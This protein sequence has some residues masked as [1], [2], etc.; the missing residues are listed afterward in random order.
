MQPITDAL[1]SE[2]FFF[3]FN[4]DTNR[5]YN[6]AIMLFAFRSDVFIRRWNR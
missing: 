3:F 4:R 5:D 2:L 6:D 1:Y